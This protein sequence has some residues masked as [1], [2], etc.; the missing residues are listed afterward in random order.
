MVRVSV[1]NYSSR[2]VPH[3]KSM[4]MRDFLRKNGRK[5]R[6]PKSPLVYID[7]K[8]A[9]PNDPINDESHVTITPRFVS[10]KTGTDG[11]KRKE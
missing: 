10:F 8:I 5:I 9:L 3:K 7:G 11:V 2:R 1:M 6:L 4:R